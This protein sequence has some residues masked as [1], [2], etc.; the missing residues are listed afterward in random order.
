MKFPE[1]RVHFLCDD[2][3]ALK[4]MKS[5]GDRSEIRFLQDLGELV[6]LCGRDMADKRGGKCWTESAA[7]LDSCSPPEP[8][9]SLTIFMNN[10]QKF[11]GVDRTV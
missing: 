10:S 4:M 7:F 5:L 6:G 11:Q 9:V 2:T 8:L 1:T 3:D